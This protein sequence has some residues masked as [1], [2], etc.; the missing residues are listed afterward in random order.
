[1]EEA[2]LLE[3]LGHVFPKITGY[4]YLKGYCREVEEAV[5]CTLFF[6]SNQLGVTSFVYLAEKGEIPQSNISNTTNI[7]T[8]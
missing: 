3:K 7:T 4:G 6:M 1:M 8:T 2:Y 5:N